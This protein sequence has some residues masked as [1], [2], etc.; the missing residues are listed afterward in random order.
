[1]KDLIMKSISVHWCVY[2]TQNKFEKRIKNAWERNEHKPRYGCD[3]RH[4]CTLAH[5]Y[6]PMHTPTHPIHT[7]CIYI[8]YVHHTIFPTG[9]KQFAGKANI[10]IKK[11]KNKSNDPNC[12]CFGM[13]P[14]EQRRRTWYDAAC[15]LHV[16][17]NVQ[18]KSTYTGK[19][20]VNHTAVDSTSTTA[21]LWSCRVGE[22]CAAHFILYSIQYCDIYI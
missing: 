20:P 18:S 13:C 8:W 12:L 9:L 2:N 22:H 7:Q 15:I 4:T 6:A 1:M 14:G 19:L 17:L 21:I 5:M 16:H 10:P 11:E 3:E